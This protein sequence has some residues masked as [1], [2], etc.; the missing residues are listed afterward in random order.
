M[1][2]A[3]L[4]DQ[5]GVWTKG[6][7]VLQLRAMGGCLGM[8]TPLP[9]PTRVMRLKPNDF[10]RPHTIQ[11]VSIQVPQTKEPERPF[12]GLGWVGGCRKPWS[13]FLG[14]EKE[15]GRNLE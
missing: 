3:L 2:Q 15:V 1:A 13:F 4:V 8:R 14:E 10:L 5:I 6:Q 9:H 7:H 12:S 11:V